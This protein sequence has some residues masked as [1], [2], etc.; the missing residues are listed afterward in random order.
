MPLP[1]AS[2]IT[3][4]EGLAPLALAA[5]WDNVGLLLEPAPG[6]GDAVRRVLFTVDLGERELDEAVAGGCELVVAYHPPIFHPLSRLTRGSA[7]ERVVLR[8]IAHGIAVYS[9]HTALDA[10]PGGV[11]DW[12]LTAFG[13]RVRDV[14]ALAPA[15]DPTGAP[16]AG[17]D[18]PAGAGRLASL[19]PPLGI[20]AAVA[21]VK[22]HLGLERVRLAAAPRHAAGEPIRSVAVCPGAGGSL[23]ADV[24]GADLFW[25]GELRHHD[26]RAHNAAGASV[27]LCD[28]TNTER[29]YLPLLAERLRAR[30]GEAV[31]VVLSARD[32]D[33]LDVV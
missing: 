27:I 6:Q 9:P 29:G 1:L 17:S 22:S 2:V 31:E 13:D 26:V 25:T 5:S 16:A 28:H 30:L 20:E 21:A 18:A 12:L 23:F 32:R 8:A 19:D 10:V 7:T 24:R 11:N 33:P 15:P 4:L 3:A 14:R